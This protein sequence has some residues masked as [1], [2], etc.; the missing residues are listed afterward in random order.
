M[1]Q[2]RFLYCEH[3]YSDGVRRLNDVKRLP[4]GRLF[5]VSCNGKIHVGREVSKAPVTQMIYGR[6]SAD[7]GR[8]WSPSGFFMEFP[9]QQAML[10]PGDFLIDADGRI[11]I[12]LLRIEK[13][14]VDES[15]G[16][17]GGIAYLRLNNAEGAGAIYRKIECLPRYTGA[18]NNAIQ[19]KNGRMIA[20]FST[21]PPVDN[22]SHFVSS[23]IYSDDGGDHWLA[24][25]D[26]SVVNDEEHLES[27]AV[28]PV[29]VEAEEGVLV[30][31]IRT[32]LNC[33]Y[34]AV[35]YDDGTTWSEARP[36]RIPASNAPSVPVRLPDGRIVLAWNN[37][38]GQ[39][40]VGVHYS[41]ARQCLHA[42][43]SCDGLKT[44]QG[45]RI[46][47]RKRAGDQDILHSSYP[48]GSVADEHHVFLRPMSFD[49]QENNGWVEP[50]GVLLRLN[51]DDLTACEMQDAFDEW[52]CDCPAEETGIRLMPT[53]K[54]LAYACVNFPYA[55]KG[56]IR[57]RADGNIP[58]GMRILMTDC[59][60]DRLTFLPGDETCRYQAAVG[61]HL[62]EL[63]PSEPGEWIIRWDANTLWLETNGQAAAFPRTDGMDGFNHMILLFEGAGD[64]NIKAFH[65]KAIE[66]GLRT[67]IEY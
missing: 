18:M 13:I 28:E 6:V 20:P 15:G 55:V 65:M 66:S 19:L 23:V 48:F 7:E 41:F 63:T 47:M 32:V 30:M 21:I 59:Y 58:T 2:K 67:G 1:E 31:L 42:A 25:N 57:L 12:F 46:I 64:V 16:C 17:I 35:S 34:Y 11:H 45:A 39:P 56:E 51:P 3:L 60:L 54:D 26:V 33:I 62:A 43:V 27:G 22:G 4:D 9:E 53:V 44:L 49:D 38:L 5:T 36:T 37:V 14:N 8:T 61:E 29:V 50:E 52:I 24:S 10:L 40:M